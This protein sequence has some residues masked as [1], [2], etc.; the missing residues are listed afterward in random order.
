MARVHFL[1]L[2]CPK[3]RVDAEHMLGLV[4]GD[5]HEI[6]ASAEEADTIVVNTC[7]F[8]GEAK[9]ESVNAILEMAEIKRDGGQRLV[10][11]GCLAQRYVGD[12]E[13]ELPEVDHFLGTADYAA[14]TELLDEGGAQ[15]ARPPAEQDGSF[16]PLSS[17]RR[18][19][20]A[21]EHGQQAPR[22]LVSSELEYVAGAGT[23][24][25]NSMPRFTAYLKIAEGCDN[26]CAFCIIPTLRGKQRSRPIEDLVAEARALA[27]EGVVELNL[28]A[29][30]LTGYGHDLDGRPK[31][32]E[33][34]AALDEVEG[35]RWIRCMYAYPR[36]LTDALL[37]QLDEGRA[38]LPYLDIPTQ[39]GSDRMLRRMK[40]GRDQRRL[41][42]LLLGVRERVR[43]AVLRSTVIVGFPGEEDEDFQKLVDFVQSVRF[44]RLGVFKYS[45]EEGTSA[46]ELDGKVPYKAH[47]EKLRELVGTVHE[48]IVEGPSEEHEYLV[49]G[50]L[51]SQAP[52]IDGITYLSSTRPLRAGEIVH[53]RVTDSHDYDLVAEVLEEGDPDER[54]SVPFLVRQS[55]AGEGSVS[56]AASP[57]R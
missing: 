30:D 51:W 7:A 49:V 12:L 24:R 43:N 4:R 31:L 16:V 56:I 17:L 14:I 33:L 48:A 5:G 28:I 39:H 2:G 54:A 21:H 53:V 13:G 18:A 9:V 19:R 50:R 46:F 57:S 23:P 38:V 37:A 45:D 27:A 15:R 47:K 20:E 32:H 41:T 52:E 42:S 3:N 44:E 22:N 29:Q 34:L 1:S 26:A 10:V 11:S 40:R 6:V 55:A 8:I 36:T 35:L 25:V